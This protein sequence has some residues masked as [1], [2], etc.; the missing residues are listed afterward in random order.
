MLG[1]EAGQELGVRL[2]EARLHRLEEQPHPLGE[3]ELPVPLV[4][5]P[6][7]GHGRRGPRRLHDH[8]VVGDPAHPPD[9]GAQGEAVPHR[10]LPDE[11]LVELSDLGPGPV[12]A[13]LDPEVEVAPVGD[14]A[15]GEVDE[16]RG[17]GAGADG[18]LHA[19]DGHPG[20]SSRT[21]LSA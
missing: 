19:V 13:A 4:G 8:V 2:L 1:G 15:A 12:R 16:A 3:E 11:L 14:R 9:L 18:P 21:R 5:A 20:E 6:E 7:R 10:A 17:A